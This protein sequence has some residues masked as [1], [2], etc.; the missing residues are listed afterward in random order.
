MPPIESKTKKTEPEWLKHYLGRKSSE[1]VG[2][3]DKDVST[4]VSVADYL[5]E[6][7]KHL[8]LT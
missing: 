7:Y 5:D 1:T 8:N 3:T 2:S 6:K 4:T